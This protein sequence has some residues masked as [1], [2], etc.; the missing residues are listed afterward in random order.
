MIYKISFKGILNIS[1]K[2]LKTGSFNRTS[3]IN[4]VEIQLQKYPKKVWSYPFFL[5][6]HSIVDLNRNKNLRSG[7]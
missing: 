4:I 3:T 5:T 6:K 1:L 7:I 2:M